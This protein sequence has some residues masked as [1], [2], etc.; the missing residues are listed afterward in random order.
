MSKTCRLLLGPRGKLHSCTLTEVVSELW[1]WNRYLTRFR[2]CQIG[3]AKKQ[4]STL[5]LNCAQF[6]VPDN[7]KLQGDPDWIALSQMSGNSSL[8]SAFTVGEEHRGVDPNV[9]IATIAQESM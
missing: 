5:A 8:P 6:R 4:N 7:W 1:A 2:E 3:F 9:L